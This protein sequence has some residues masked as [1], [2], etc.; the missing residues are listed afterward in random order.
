M[1]RKTIFDMT[2]GRCFYCGCQLDFQSFHIDHIKPRASGGKDRNNCVP[3]CIDCNLS[4]G[5]LSIEEF[6]DKLSR[7]LDDSH[8]G[9]MIDKYYHPKRKPI[10]F[11]F[12]ETTNGRTKNVC[13]DNHR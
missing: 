4:K 7:L 8:K 5:S 3:A 12:E 11:Y 2:E 13:K 6:R 9:K 1:N 10:K